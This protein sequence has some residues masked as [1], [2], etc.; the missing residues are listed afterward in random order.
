[1][2]KFIDIKEGLQ[3]QNRT[4]RASYLIAQTQKEDKLKAA[5]ELAA[6][7]S[8]ESKKRN[9]LLTIFI[10]TLG[11]LIAIIIALRL[12]RKQSK[13]FK[14]EKLEKQIIRGQ[15]TALSAQM[16]PHFIFNSLNSIQD[17]ILKQDSTQAYDYVGKFALLIRRILD[18]S[19]KEFIDIEE[20]YEIL[21]LYLELEKLRFQEGFSYVIETNEI[22]D[23]E[24]P[25]MLIQPFVEN[26][27][28][29][30]LLHKKGTKTL[31]VSFELLKNVLQVS[32][33]DNGIGRDA[34]LKIKAR[35]NKEHQSFA[36]QSMDKRL[37]I[38]RKQYGGDF[39]VEYLDLID[40]K[41]SCIGT[42][43]IISSPFKR[44]Y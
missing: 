21:N 12:W 7:K 40:N 2:D 24:I 10:I 37:E 26:A 29:H 17:L 18:H 35:Q 14:Q 16:N 13:L 1:M 9:T 5:K 39:H 22:R 44:K 43:V 30:G 20:E 8:E 36:G 38:L 3:S 19:E 25:P 28:K 31:N 41:S 6:M 34:A 27:I 42:K 4:A 15:L 11:S 32:I 23:I 33:Q